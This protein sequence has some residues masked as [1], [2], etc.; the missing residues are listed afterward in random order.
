M[1]RTPRSAR[2]FHDLA[3]LGLAL[4]LATGAAASPP[5]VQAGEPIP[6][7]PL[8]VVWSHATP[9]AEGVTVS[10][11]V[12]RILVRPGPARGYIRIDAPRSGDGTVTTVCLASRDLRPAG[13]RGGTFSA[14]FHGPY[15]AEGVTVRYVRE[16]S[17][18][19][20]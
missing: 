3:G 11:L 6:A 2:P 7:D 10:G 18:R 5:P 19:P 8:R 15:R 16:C 4:C 17:P 9:R 20:A 13:S 14:W 1:A 12:R